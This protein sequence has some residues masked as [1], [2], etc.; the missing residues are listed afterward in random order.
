MELIVYLDG[1]EDAE[2]VTAFVAAKSAKFDSHSLILTM[3]E[4]QSLQRILFRA[5]VRTEI[6]QQKGEPLA[7]A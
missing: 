4:Q 3:R 2:T 7:S 6:I 5:A 1:I